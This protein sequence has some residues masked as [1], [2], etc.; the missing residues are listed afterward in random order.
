MQAVE[1]RPSRGSSRKSLHVLRYEFGQS[2]WVPQPARPW[3]A[4]TS[5]KRS[6]LRY[7]TE[8]YRSTCLTFL[9]S[10]KGD[11]KN[12]FFQV[13]YVSLFHKEN[14]LSV[15]IDIWMIFTVYGPKLHGTVR[16]YDWKF[17]FL[18]KYVFLKKKKNMF[19]MI[20]LI[21]I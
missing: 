6:P 13:P 16:F 19:L 3:P 5:S 14:K 18:S 2:S 12:M 1:D 20:L 9:V 15:K 21:W 8:W 11:V 4:V 10:G 7:G 17:T